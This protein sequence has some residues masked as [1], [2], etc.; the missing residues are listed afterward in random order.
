MRTL[1]DVC[2]C[3]EKFC[4]TLACVTQESIFP[5]C[6]CAQISARNIRRSTEFVQLI[7]N[8]RQ[9]KTLCL[10]KEQSMQKISRYAGRNNSTY[11]QR[12]ISTPLHRL[13]I[14]R[15]TA[16]GIRVEHLLGGGGQKSPMESGLQLFLHQLYQLIKNGLV[17]VRL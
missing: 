14:L 11:A 4:A 8:I 15:R 17:L 9:T 13:K 2:V 3:A 5:Y 7:M 6:N 10:K 1:F 12:K 16:N